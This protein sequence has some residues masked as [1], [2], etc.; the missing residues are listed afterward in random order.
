MTSEHYD[1]L[2]DLYERALG[3]NAAERDSLLQSTLRKAPDVGRQLG[4]LLRNGSRGP[5]PSEDAGETFRAAFQATRQP[6]APER[7]GPYRI[8]APIGQGTA[9]VVYLAVQDGSGDRVAIKVLRPQ[10]RDSPKTVERFIREASATFRL[11]DVTGVVPVT[12]KGRHDGLPYLVM[13]FVQGQSLR[14]VIECRT[15]D[16]GLGRG[17]ARPGQQSGESYEEWCVRTAVVMLRAIS[18][19]HQRG[20]LHRDI[21]PENILIDVDGKPWLV[22]FGLAKD[23]EMLSLSLPGEFQGTPAYA[24]PQQLFSDASIDHRTDIYS[25]GVV[26]YEMLSLRHPFAH[27]SREGLLHE[28][29]TGYP[30]PLSSLNG[31]VPQDLQ[32]ICHKALE[33]NPDNRYE[34]AEEMATDLDRFLGGLRITAKPPGYWTRLKR[35]SHRHQKLAAVSGLLVI[36]AVVIAASFVGRFSERDKIRSRISEIDSLRRRL[37]NALVSGIVSPEEMPRL[38]SGLV[39]TNTVGYDDSKV[40][41]ESEEAARQLEEQLDRF[42]AEFATA[43]WSQAVEEQLL[44]ARAT[45][46]NIQGRSEEALLLLESASAKRIIERAALTAGA[47]AFASSNTGR[48]KDAIRWYEFAVR[49]EPENIEF[50]HNLALAYLGVNDWDSGSRYVELAIA[51]DGA[52]TQALITKSAICSKFEDWKGA[53]EACRKVTNL[54]PDNP[55]ALSNLGMALHHLGD[56]RGAL[57]AINRAI[58]VA[59][60]FASAHANQGVVLAEL[61][62]FERALEAYDRALLLRPHL[63]GTRNNKVLA[64]ANMGH[65]AEALELCDQ[66]LTTES[67]SGFLLPTR[68]VLLSELERHEEALAVSRHAVATRP[69]MAE[70]HF[71]RGFALEKAGRYAMAKTEYEEC[72]ELSPDHPFAATRRDRLT[73]L[74]LLSPITDLL[75]TPPP[76]DD[77]VQPSDSEDR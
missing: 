71:A 37:D 38:A 17:E 57:K 32:T 30:P 25:I 45:V 9:G 5:L 73:V 51:H 18:V 59:P 43:S 56:D 44:I 6:P 20:I 74:R 14:R 31:K 21:K 62:S 11:R 75:R 4:A 24:S 2:M 35:W 26:L 3:L 55:V 53:L 61:G 12:Q 58:A 36:L 22:D 8:H 65:H 28:I 49:A 33:R 77:S 60:R 27:N 1:H 41:A 66:I 64:L 50:L 52:F 42:E 34:D 39:S 68:A 69:G 13:P 72:L 70:A 54:E 29:S 48:P 19:A 76:G 46:L 15:S 23:K 67:G 63:A 16:R 10:W 40:D 47:L 7:I